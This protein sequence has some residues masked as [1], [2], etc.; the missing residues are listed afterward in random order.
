MKTIYVSIGNS[1]NKLTQQTWHYYCGRVRGLLNT[2]G[3]FHG[4]W[5]SLP[6]S[7][8]QNA[9]WC[10]EISYGFVGVKR[11]LAQIAAMFQQDSISWA[12]AKTTMIGPYAVVRPE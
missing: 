9:C 6:N 12:E 11:A 10:V 7:E 5:Y 4:E 3:K 2:S 1:D 8:F